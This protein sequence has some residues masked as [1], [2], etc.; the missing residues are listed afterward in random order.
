[1]LNAFQES[2]LDAM[3]AA[4]ETFTLEDYISLFFYDGPTSPEIV[5]SELVSVGK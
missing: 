4:V 5:S 1:M 3:T 2:D